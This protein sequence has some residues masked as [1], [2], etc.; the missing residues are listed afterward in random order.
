MM[1]NVSREKKHA[2]NRIIVDQIEISKRIDNK[3]LKRK[4]IDS[5]GDEITGSTKQIARRFLQ[6]YL[7]ESSLHGVKYLGKLQIKSTILGKLFWTFI[8][9]S[10]LAFVIWMF[11]KTWIRYRDNPTRTVIESYHAPVALIPFPA[12][13]VCPLVLPPST[14]REKVLRSLQLPPNMSNKTAK[15]LLKYGPSFANEHVLGNRKYINDLDALL[16][17]NRLTLINFLELMRPCED[18][19][20]ICWWDG[21]EKNCTE[22]F[23]LSYAY[24][25]LCC[26]F[27]YVLED[28]IRTDKITKDS[29]LRT[30]MLFGPRAGLTVV[31]K[32]DLLPNSH[33]GRDKNVKYSTNSY[34]LLIYCHHPLE[35]VG[36]IYT[37]QLLQASEELRVSIVP[38][39]KR[40]LPGYYRRNSRGGWTPICIDKNN[41]KYF[42]AYR[43]SN[44]FTSCSIEAVLE[45]CGCIPYYYAPVA[46]KYSLRICEWRDFECLYN[47]TKRIR[48]LHNT[49]TKNFT[50][51]CQNPCWNVYYETR[52]SSLLLNDDDNS[53]ILPFYKNITSSQAVLR[54][55]FGYDTV[56]ETITIPIADELYLLA[57]VGGIFSLLLG[58][59]F[60][61]AVEIFYFIEL[62]FRSYY[63]EKKSK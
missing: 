44:C 48:I 22:L 33:N 13:T 25:G 1:L 15:L 11:R 31:V 59:S 8:M 34:G 51:E 63:K 14:R 32:R 30:T 9:I 18:L 53:N 57:S 23:K 16:K 24:S 2:V 52:T 3:S 38:F 36:P 19:F 58:A 47:N 42:P 49:Y 50:C 46:D 26:S 7:Y 56:M 41:L 17:I 55:F 20:E 21:D 61:S 54:V 28:D 27:N 6:E 4:N 40:N 43:Y 37:R 39:T 12:I 45:I 62:F 5:Y 35:Y 29:D 10:S 60:I